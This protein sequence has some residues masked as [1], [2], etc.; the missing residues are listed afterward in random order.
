MQVAF[1]ADASLQIGTGHVM[2]CLTLADALRAKGAQCTFLCREHPGDLIGH[3]ERL[4]YKVHRLHMTDDID[5]DLA[6][7]AWLGATKMQ[8][9]HAC[10]PLLSTLRPDWLVVDHYALDVCWESRLA[11]HCGSVMVIDDLADRVHDCRLLLDQNF[12]RNV[13]DYINRAPSDCTLLCG[14]SYA[15]LRPEFSL[16]RPFS[17]QRRSEFT[18]KKLL[19]T[20][21]GIDQENVTA[22]VMVALR[23]CP[24]PVDCEITV[25]MG[26]MAPWL[27]DVEVLA[28][29][30]PWLT[31]VHT[32][33]KN[34]ANLMTGSDLAIGAAG[35]TSWE[36]CCLGLP[37]VLVVVAENQA[38]IAAAL[39]EA[40]AAIQ[41]ELSDLS[42]FLPLALTCQLDQSRLKLMSEAARQICDGEGTTRV[43]SLMMKI[44]DK[45]Q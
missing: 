31:Q 5:L 17:L 24:L 15:L 18:L 10:E 28:S 13:A 37:S 33:V 20:M 3:I 14:S 26:Q 25:V 2:R 35:S 9:I 42:A 7:S 40:H 22:K 39:S 41:V 27:K 11:K 4:G 1:R 34:M 44:N 45:N 12:G 30:M 36:R 23:N 19:I 43:V 32:G 29:Q 38:S 16:C 8:D 21:G 6:H